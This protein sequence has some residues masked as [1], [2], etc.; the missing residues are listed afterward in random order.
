[1]LYILRYVFFGGSLLYPSF[2]FSLVL[3]FIPSV[4]EAVMSHVSIGVN[5]EYLFSKQLAMI[6]RFRGVPTGI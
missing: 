3:A 4:L 5:C 1:M 2:Y 6:N